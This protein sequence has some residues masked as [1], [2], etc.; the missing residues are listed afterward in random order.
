MKINNLFGSIE[1]SDE[2]TWQ[3]DHVVEVNNKV[4][5]RQDC[6]EHDHICPYCHPEVKDAT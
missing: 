5:P 1:I 3:S 6:I 2:P 4:C